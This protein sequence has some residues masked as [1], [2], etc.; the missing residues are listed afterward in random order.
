[1]SLYQS[2]R[3]AASVAL[4]LVVMTAACVNNF[5]DLHG[6][7]IPLAHA[8]VQRPAT[9]LLSPV[10]AHLKDGST[11]VYT[12][13]LRVDSLSIRGEGVAFSLLADLGRPRI[14]PIPLDSLVALEAFEEHTKAGAS[15]VATLAATAAGA[16]AVLLLWFVILASLSS[17]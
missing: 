13:G 12:H 6:R 11:V 17:G 1:M 16:F 14:T 3:P 8:T 2:F 5:V 4:L 9:A 7:A 10:R 15:S